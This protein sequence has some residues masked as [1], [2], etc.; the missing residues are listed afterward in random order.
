V[1]DDDA[2]NGV[3]SAAYAAAVV[4]IPAVFSAANFRRTVGAACE[5]LG[6]LQGRLG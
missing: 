1:F 5:G 4:R 2:K 6:C 3:G